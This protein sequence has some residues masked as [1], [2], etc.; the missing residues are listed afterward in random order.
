MN[1]IYNL[2]RYEQVVRL[3]LLPR[4]A[5]LKAKI[6]TR[7]GRKPIKLDGEIHA[8]QTAPEHQTKLSEI[9]P[10]LVEAR[11]DWHDC[12]R[13]STANKNIVTLR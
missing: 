5:A 7:N 11:A 3:K 13:R 2:A 10:W 6:K 4:T 9:R 12:R 8:H 1:L